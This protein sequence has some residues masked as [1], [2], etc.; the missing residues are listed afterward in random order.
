MAS[1]TAK[2]P[3]RAV[4]AAAA[5]PAEGAASQGLA[6]GIAEQLKQLIHSGEI[7][8]GERLNEAALALRMGTSRGPIREAIRMITGIGLVTAVPNRGV[9]VRQIS[10]REMLEIY[11]LRALLF[12]FAAQQAA[13]GITATQQRE[14]EHLLQQMDSACE[15][16][17]A[18]RYY[19]VNLRFHTLV[20]ELGRN[21]RAHQAYDDYVKELH[22]F[23]RSYF[24]AA[25]NMRRS[26]VEHRQIYEAIA[27]GSTT[28]ARSLAQKHV[29]EGRG[30]LLATLD[31]AL[32][33]AAPA[34]AR[35]RTV[36][37]ETMPL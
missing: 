24:D 29:L 19:S 30:R 6:H 8:P 3:F 26:N 21:R 18:D 16:G 9:F 12:G 35:K 20:L 5:A 31:T 14:F 7:A 2:Q 1:R 15:R 33:G 11:E 32:P 22:L 34:P 28:R 4:P 27:A 37:N 10:V 36:R 23:R 13:E 17:D 25:G